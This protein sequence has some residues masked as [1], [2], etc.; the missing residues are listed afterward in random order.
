MKVSRKFG[1]RVFNGLAI[2]AALGAQ[3]AFAQADM[4]LLR[5]GSFYCVAAMPGYIDRL[6]D[7]NNDVAAIAARAKGIYDGACVGASA[8]HYAIGDVKAH[9]TKAGGRYL[10]FGMRDMLGDGKVTDARHCALQTAITTIGEEVKKRRG[11]FE[12]IN[13]TKARIRANCIEGGSV[14][15]FF[16]KNQWKRSSLVFPTV[17]DFNDDTPQSFPVVSADMRTELRDGC[18]G[19]DHVVVKKKLQ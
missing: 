3:H 10:C 8:E 1:S 17:D 15:L 4:Q 2:I 18:R 12:V 5:A 19:V 14:A 13:Q 16:E 9:A 7:A 11:D 6:A